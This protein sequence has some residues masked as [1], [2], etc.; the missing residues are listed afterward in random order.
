M[1][2]VVYVIQNSPDLH[3]IFVRFSQPKSFNIFRIFDG[4]ER[5]HPFGSHA[6]YICIYNNIKT[7]R[8]IITLRL[9]ELSKLVVA[10][11]KHTFSLTC[12]TRYCA[13]MYLF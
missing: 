7:V 9:L 3:K 11:L 6:I 1:S 12:I 8:T 10:L 13:C 4:Y 2:V 5:L